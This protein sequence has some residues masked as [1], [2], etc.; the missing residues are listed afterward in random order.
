[1]L[2]ENGIPPEN[3]QIVASGS[4][5]PPTPA[6]A[7]APGGD[8]APNQT[9]AL[10]ASGQ[11]KAAPLP[12]VIPQKGKKQ[13]KP[14][15]GQPALAAAL[16]AL[17]T[18]GVVLAGLLL[19]TVL[20]LQG[21]PVATTGVQPTDMMMQPQPATTQSLS[22]QQ[23]IERVGPSVVSI[24]LYEEGSLAAV[25]SGSGVIFSE[26]GLIITNYHVIADAY[27]IRVILHDETGY[28]ATLVE[29]DIV[30]DLAIIKIEATGLT[31]AE[32][33]NSDNVKKGETVIAIG[34]AAGLPGSLSQG[35]ISGINRQ[36][37]VK[38]ADGQTVTR[39]YLQTDAAINPGNSG[40]A[41]VNQYAQVIGINV[42]KLSAEDIDNIG[43]AIPIKTALPLMQEL[44]VDGQGREAKPRIGVTVRELNETNGPANGLPSWG[45]YI[46]EIAE[47]SN[48]KDFP[49][50][51]GDVIMEADGTALLTMKDLDGVLATHKPGD[52]VMLLVYRAQQDDTLLVSLTLL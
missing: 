2:H 47:D 29:K 39:T 45:L 27:A 16:A 19:N 14:A 8:G 9:Q 33:G 48:L 10:P 23:I 5:A 12:K 7:A 4:A 24:D 46:E 31:P 21:K 20:G 49:V 42:A 41:L 32:F 13:K 50:S 28:S 26:D 40:G 1:M 3:S 34:N 18:V 37:S 17:F 52:S 15:N 30:N 43:F 22:A 44:T 36:L 35:I 25:G 6:Q 38:A 11:A 51:A